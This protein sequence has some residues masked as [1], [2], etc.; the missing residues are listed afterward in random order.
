MDGLRN[1]K[2]NMMALVLKIIGYVLRYGPLVLSIVREV[3][4]LFGDKTGEEKLDAAMRLIK[5]ALVSRGVAW[6]DEMQKIIRGILE[7]A[8]GA[9]D[10]FKAWRKERVASKLIAEGRL[11]ANARIP[12]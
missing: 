2:E 7:M 5:Q 3:E 4:V 9:L 11:P 10:M 12:Q 8:V 6:T 1:N